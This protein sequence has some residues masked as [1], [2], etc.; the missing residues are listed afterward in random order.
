VKAK[1]RAAGPALR[2]IASR[3]IAKVIK[4]WAMEAA[5]R[6]EQEALLELCARA[7]GLTPPGQAAADRDD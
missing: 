3:F 2:V 1:V 7:L 6:Q 4:L 5:V